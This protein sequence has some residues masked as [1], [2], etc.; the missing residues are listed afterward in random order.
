[1]SGFT[2]FEQ[3]L[4]RRLLATPP[5]TR[6]PELVE[7][8]IDIAAAQLE[9]PDAILAATVL[10]TAFESRWHRGGEPEDWDA[11]V[12]GYQQL[13]RLPQFELMAR[14]SVAKLMGQR[15]LREEDKDLD[16]LRSTINLLADL[17][18]RTPQDT[19]A[20]A[21]RASNLG[22]FLSAG[23]RDHLDQDIFEYANTEFRGLL[24]TVPMADSYQAALRVHLADMLLVACR[25]GWLD[26]DAEAVDLLHRAASQITGGPERSA[27]VQRAG[28]ASLQRAQVRL[29]RGE[30][31]RALTCL[32]EAVT[33]DPDPWL[34]VGLATALS[35]RAE[36]D[37]SPADLR[38]A[39]SLLAGLVPNLVTGSEER[40]AAIIHW[41][42]LQSQLADRDQNEPALDKAIELL[43][44]A[45]GLAEQGDDRQYITVSRMNLGVAHRIRARL[46]RRSGD[47]GLAID[48]LVIARKS[49]PDRRFEV[50]V[51]ARLGSAHL[52][53]YSA[54]GAAA[55]LRRAVVELEAAAASQ[56]PGTPLTVELRRDL[57]LARAH[58]ATSGTAH[59]DRLDESLQQ[60]RDL[61]AEVEAHG[62]P[63]P[64]V[65]SALAEAL[66]LKLRT[67]PDDSLLTEFLALTGGSRPT[68]GASINEPTTAD[69]A[70]AT[71]SAAL[72][73]YLSTGWDS[74]L[75]QAI[76]VLRTGTTRPS[77][78]ELEAQ[79]YDLLG[80]AMQHRFRLT[81]VEDDLDEAVAANRRAAGFDDPD[82]ARAGVRLVNLA[83]ALRLRFE[84]VVDEAAL[85]DA[86]DVG[87]RAVQLLPVG[88]PERAR[89]LSS[90]GHTLAL[91]IGSEADVGKLVD[92]RRAALAA[93]TPGDEKLPMYT[94]HLARALMM[95]YQLRQA[96]ADLN[97]VTRLVDDPATSP[98][99]EASGQVIV[100]VADL[101]RLLLRRRFDETKL[102]RATSLLQTV[103][104]SVPDGH[105]TQVSAFQILAELLQLRF[106][107][108]G[109]VTDLSEAIGVGERLL[110]V[111]APNHRVRPV[112]TAKLGWALVLR[113]RHTNTS[114]DLDA[115]LDL[116]ASALEAIP[117]GDENRPDTLLRLSNTCRFRFESG[118]GDGRDLAAAIQAVVE[119]WQLPMLPSAQVR[120][121]TALLALRLLRF[122]LLG[123]SKDLDE[124][125]ESGR[126][127]QELLTDDPE[128]QVRAA[129]GLAQ[130]L[131][132]RFRYHGSPRDVEAS[133]A[134][135]KQAEA[136]ADRDSL[137]AAARTAR[138]LTW[139]ARYERTGQL[140]DLDRAVHE[141]RAALELTT[142]GSPERATIQQNLGIA[143]HVQF[144]VTTE[145]GVLN[146]A[147]TVLRAAAASTAAASPTRSGALA[148]LGIALRARFGL[149]RQTKDLQDA[150]AVHEEA[151]A[152]V[153]NDSDRRV[154]LTNLASTLEARASISPNLDPDDLRSAVEKLRAASSLEP[155]E[156][157]M[158]CTTLSALGHT[159]RRLAP[160]DGQKLLEEAADRFREASSLFAAPPQDRVQAAHNWAD[161]AHALGN[162]GQAVEGFRV[163]VDLLPRMAWHGL[164]RRS[165]EIHL[166]RVNGLAPTAAAA[167][168]LVRRD[169][170]AVELLE[171]GRSVLWTQ[172][173]AFSA[174]HSALARKAPDLEKRLR[175][176]S[177]DLSAGET[178][179]LRS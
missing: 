10:A 94:V 116:I 80:K 120:A 143:L 111:M 17:L 139:Q 159:L 106:A 131:R 32:S 95:R 126:S 118:W 157:P 107:H 18:A 175:E 82:Q 46:S 78:P 14:G 178:I 69:Q 129:L 31:Q 173:L 86:A 160:T 68:D 91:G 105:P 61:R 161:V 43:T 122:Q 117:L 151:V 40:L 62:H 96:D 81:F 21:G 154:A 174:A 134:I 114:T 172:A 53:R 158:R 112:A 65:R 119:A 171:A 52:A 3:M 124:A 55:D 75:D 4:V 63:D 125:V 121:L 109:E 29:D 41:G 110:A 98:G 167:A 25:Q 135:V 128:D 140:E 48:H 22:T 177:R 11:A 57:A 51:G 169:D 64:L 28:L 93:C 144:Q 170:E 103:T 89:A 8:I 102:D 38:R 23:V 27:V 113:A 33:L 15:Y 163:A 44:E 12:G 90:L 148:N 165:R 152:A 153:T 45:V 16:L 137:R 88:H 60:L 2:Q 104:T 74:Q 162:P 76:E 138:G 136:A 83:N 30:L 50:L 115:G 108:S 150:I 79:L 101:L 132:E 73:Q 49:A 9:G 168:T 97:E 54:E 47:L 34:R 67:D 156:H 176:L 155:S 166:A 123:D 77:S 39:E 85:A 70:L 56:R 146:D 87:R 1:M 37:G 99:S 24:M 59:E 179:G 145:P 84:A 92:I 35:M 147:I 58:T 42:D 149:D 5:E 13:A 142:P 36:L 20:Y 6:D 127:A 72:D 7:Q 26:D 164:T 19:A 100:Q 71:G 66:E 133:I 141:L 130:A